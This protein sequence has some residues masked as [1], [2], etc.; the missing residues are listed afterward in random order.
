MQILSVYCDK[1]HKHDFTMLKESNVSINEEVYKLAD[2]GYVGIS[3]I[4]SNSII[5]HKKSKN[6]PL[7]KEQKKENRLFSAQRIAIEQV[8]RRCKI[9]RS[10]KE[11]YR[12]K[13]RNYSKTWNV[14]AGLINLRSGID[15]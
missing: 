12:G 8:N 11:V 10:V 14:I 6:N 3:K 5:P 13:H 1:G 9:F 7:T 4:M 2:L 15:I